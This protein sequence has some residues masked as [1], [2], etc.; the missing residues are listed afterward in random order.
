MATASPTSP[1]SQHPRISS[2]SL[3][4]SIPR[5]AFI[6]SMPRN[7]LIDLPPFSEADKLQKASY[8]AG[9]TNAKRSDDVKELQISVKVIITEASKVIRDA[10]KKMNLMSSLNQIIASSRPPSKKWKVLVHS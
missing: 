5:N 10:G 1:P 7:M 9:T 2:I 6:L 8:D 3:C 4:S